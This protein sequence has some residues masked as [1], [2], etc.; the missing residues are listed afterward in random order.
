[1]GANLCGCN[2]NENHEIL[3][4]NVFNIIHNSFLFLV[5]QFQN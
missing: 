4:Q 3:E 1:M 5:R 2:K